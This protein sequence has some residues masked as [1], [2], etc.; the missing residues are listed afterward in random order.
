MKEYFASKNSKDFKNSKKYWQFYSASIKIKSDKSAN[1]NL[2]LQELNC[3]SS[4]S[5]NPDE[6]CNIFNLFFTNFSSTSLSTK[7]E[8]YQF[9]NSTF[10]VLKRENKIAT[11][12]F[13]FVPTTAKI[14]ELLLAK[15]ESSS[16]AGISGLPS[17]VL[18]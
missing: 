13:P 18:K 10:S 4:T 3:D 1:N 17:K 11:S 15:L 16:G 8:S 2:P 7:E 6:F 14:I 5:T 12:T 9:I